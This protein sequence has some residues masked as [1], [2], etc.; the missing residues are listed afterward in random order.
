M[1]V[2]VWAAPGQ[3]P[4]APNASPRS[5]SWERNACPPSTSWVASPGQGST[6]LP[7][8]TH[9]SNF[10]VR[11]WCPGRMSPKATD[12]S[13]L[14]RLQR[15]LHVPRC[16]TSSRGG[17]H[18][19]AMAPGSSS[20]PHKVPTTSSWPSPRDPADRAVF[21]HHRLA[22]NDERQRLTERFPCGLE[23]AVRREVL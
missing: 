8:F 15:I 5:S 6:T 16:R 17:L 12:L 22:G 11:H 1:F 14:L 9:F 23:Q 10:T 3:Q 19:L 7:Q 20:P 4:W 18:H 21:D 13:S 2:G